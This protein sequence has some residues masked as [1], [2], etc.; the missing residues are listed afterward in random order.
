VQ[1][2]RVLFG[3]G[4]WQADTAA[5]RT[6]DQVRQ[7]GPRSVRIWALWR[8]IR[9]R[10]GYDFRGLERAVSMAR[11]HG[12][13]PQVVLTGQGD[14]VSPRRF[15]QFA[16]AIGRRF[17]GRVGTYALWNEPNCCGWLRP[18]ETCRGPDGDVVDADRIV[19]PPAQV[20]VWRD[21]RVVRRRGGRRVQRWVS[22]RTVRQG[23]TAYECSRAG[24]A[25]AYRDLFIAASRSLRRA[26]P[27]AAILL[28]E[29]SPMEHATVF[30]RRLLCLDRPRASCAPL[31]ADGVSHHPYQG[32]APE[33]PGVT[34]KIGIG[35]LDRLNSIV[36]AAVR[37]GRLRTP[38]GRRP[39]LHLTEF[40]YQVRGPKPTVTP[41]EAGIWWPRALDAAARAGAVQLFVYQLVENPWSV[42]DTSIIRVD[43]SLEP[44][45]E[46]IRRWV[47]RA[48]G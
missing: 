9:V 25:D 46:A 5:A 31:I 32:Y 21:V 18:P 8:E 40:G 27:S 39:T 24:L 1:D 26:D 13:R 45:F 43:G 3:H 15:A 16:G 29:T 11:G 38:A 19:Q 34:H 22:R 36:A 41:R 35:S 42:W 47:R 20:G 33:R 48:S 2:D 28:G 17:R 30:W 23:T 12:L 14:A 7:L 4:T 44:A 6:W 10:G 37:S